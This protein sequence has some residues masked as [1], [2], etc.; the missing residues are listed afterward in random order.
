MLFRSP[1]SATGLENGITGSGLEDEFTR[2][3][4]ASRKEPSGGSTTESSDSDGAV[5]TS[6][7][8]RVDLVPSSHAAVVKLGIV[9][10]LGPDGKRREASAATDVTDLTESSDAGH[11][12][13]PARPQSADPEGDAGSRSSRHIEMPTSDS[14]S[15]LKPV[16]RSAPALSINSFD[17]MRV[18]GKGC[19][20]KVSP[21]FHVLL[22]SWINAVW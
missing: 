15:S 12:E 13:L 19:A 5:D 20:G 7:A 17:I 9:S 18:L 6:A 1:L 2:S 16:K 4:S 21:R 3:L 10:E 14:K 8:Q 22:V 11:F